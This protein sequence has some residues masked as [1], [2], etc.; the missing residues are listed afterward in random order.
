MKR[1]RKLERG[2]QQRRGA[3]LR[4]CPR[5]ARLGEMRQQLG[6]SLLAEMAHDFFERF[7]TI[8]GGA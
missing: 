7:S 6:E 4:H 8:D 5:L 1:A 2:E 3:A